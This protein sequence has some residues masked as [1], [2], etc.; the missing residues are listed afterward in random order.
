MGL[1]IPPQLNAS[2]YIVDIKD[3]QKWHEKSISEPKQKYI[4]CKS[5][6]LIQVILNVEV[7]H[8]RQHNRVDQLR[9]DRFE[10]E[11]GLV[12]GL[13]E[14]PLES[15][16]KSHHLLHDDVDDRNGDGDDEGQKIIL[17]LFLLLD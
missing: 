12:F 17:R 2:E 5:I 15:C 3:L 4:I 8:N 9:Q 11:I 6:P 7:N 14:L 16:E 1:P 10:S 13:S